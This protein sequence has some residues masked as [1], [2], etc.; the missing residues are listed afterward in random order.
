[1][2]YAH[3]LALVLIFVTG[4][5]SQAAPQLDIQ[6]IPDGIAVI[7]GLVAVGPAQLDVHTQGQILDLQQTIGGITVSVHW[8]Y[9][10]TEKVLVGYTVR[11]ADGHRHEP[12]NVSLIST[13]GQPFPLQGGFGL[14]GT[15]EILGMTL[16]PGHSAN[17]SQF[18]M[19]EQIDVTTPTPV[20]FTLETEEW[21]LPPPKPPTLWDQLRDTFRRGQPEPQEDAQV[22]AQPIPVGRKTG[23][24]IFE[25][26][27]PPVR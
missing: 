12:T 14:V 16:P 15:S 5:A 22:I 26:A 6:A 17:V 18:A 7:Q 23:P 10:D 2:R 3:I 24:F 1:M 21:L 25:F 4:C 9:A 8:V 19:I 13:H 27:L 11:S 20:R